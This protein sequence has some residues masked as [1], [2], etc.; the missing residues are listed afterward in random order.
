MTRS[1]AAEN[2]QR[3]IRATRDAVAAEG[4]AVRVRTI[5][6][7]AG[8][9]LSTVY[10]HFPDKD[11]LVDAVSVARWDTLS[12]LATRAAPAADALSVIVLLAD[13]FSRTVTADAGFLESTGLQVGRSPSA[14]E[15][16]KRRFDQALARWWAQAV[17]AGDLHPDADPRDL[18]QLTGA[19]RDPARRA[20]Q[21]GVLVRGV[22]CRPERA[23]DLLRG[24]LRAAAPDC[25]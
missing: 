21:L 3:L 25:T 9:S 19:L 16:P 5:A 24:H 14:I 4:P 2:V 15:E 20:A 11:G 12:G 22:S 17:R 1:D 23:T 6:D 13:R 7:R 10:R 8:V 18:V